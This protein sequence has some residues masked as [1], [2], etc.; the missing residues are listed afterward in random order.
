MSDLHELTNNPKIKK[1]RFLH[2]RKPAYR[3]DKGGRRLGI[4]RRQFWYSHYFPERRLGLERRIH[5]ER[6]VDARP[7]P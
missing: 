5:P 1:A 7:E 3:I 2:M 4:E 6:R